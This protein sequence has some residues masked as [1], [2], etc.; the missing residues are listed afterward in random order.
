MK[1]SPAEVQRGQASSQETK[2]EIGVGMKVTADEKRG[3]VTFSNLY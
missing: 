1:G 2:T 3:Y